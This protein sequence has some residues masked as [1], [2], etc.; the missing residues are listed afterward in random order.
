TWRFGGSSSIVDEEAHYHRIVYRIRHP[1]TECAAEHMKI[2][3]RVVKDEGSLRLHL[4]SKPSDRVPEGVT[5]AVNCCVA[6]GE[7][8]TSHS[9]TVPPETCGLGV[10][11]EHPFLKTIQPWLEAIGGPDDRL[12]QRLS[13]RLSSRKFRGFVQPA[14][15]TADVHVQEPGLDVFPRLMYL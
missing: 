14:V 11:S 6:S 1:E 4:V 13:H 3:L 15:E 9:V 7:T 12:V 5:V 2:E 8:E 10:D